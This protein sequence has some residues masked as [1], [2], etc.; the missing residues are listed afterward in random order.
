MVIY[1]LI[2]LF[3]FSTIRTDKLNLKAYSDSRGH[4]SASDRRVKIHNNQQ[5]GTVD[6]K[7]RY[8]ANSVMLAERMHL[9]RIK[10]RAIIYAYYVCEQN[11]HK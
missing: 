1:N 8:A 3:F 9:I 2:L 11:F 6:Q 5:R 10:S 7:R 4:T